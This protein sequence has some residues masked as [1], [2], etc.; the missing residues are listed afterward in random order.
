VLASSLGDEDQLVIVVPV[1]LPDGV[2]AEGDPLEQAHLDLR[3]GIQVVDCEA[4][5]RLGGRQGRE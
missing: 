2:L 5:L 4:G 3:P 1:R